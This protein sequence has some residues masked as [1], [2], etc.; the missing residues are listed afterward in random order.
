M[1]DANKF[2]S[3]THGI[4]TL[5]KVFD[6]IMKETAGKEDEYE[7]M[8]GTDSQG[9]SEET[10]VVAVIVLWHVGH[11]G[12]FFYRVEHL[13]TFENFR[14]KIYNEAQESL[15]IAKAFVN[16]TYE[17]GVDI[18]TVI[19]VDIGENGKTKCLIDEIIGWIKSEG[20]EACYKPNS[21]AAS[22]IAD[23]YSK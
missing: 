17:A 8:I 23:Y 11:G 13:K 9:F 6:I 22:F 21:I 15:D 2:K 16:H 4:L 1:E 12:K 14:D 19:H 5:S 7:V 10:K 18:H 20:F 3:I